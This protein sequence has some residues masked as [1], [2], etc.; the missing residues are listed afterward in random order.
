MIELTN[1]AAKKLISKICK[2]SLESSSS[3]A[4]DEVTTSN[5]A[6][7]FRIKVIG[8]GCSGY[9]YKFLIDQSTTDD[10]LFFASEGLDLELVI[11]K[12]SLP[13]VSGSILDH[14]ATISG[15]HFLLK[16]PNAKAKCG[17]GSSFSV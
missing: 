4:L 13:L 9:Q 11:D 10:D 2:K 15:E 5:P 1:A 8:G 3:F 14:S 17:C 7:R 16:N 12:H 6:E